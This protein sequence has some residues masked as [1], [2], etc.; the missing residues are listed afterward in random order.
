MRVFLYQFDTTN[1]TNCMVL[2]FID[3]SSQSLKRRSKTLASK[4]EDNMMLCTNVHNELSSS[5]NVPGNGLVPIRLI[6]TKSNQNSYSSSIRKWQYYH[7]TYFKPWT[8]REKTTK[9][10]TLARQIINFK[11]HLL[12]FIAFH[13]WI[14]G[15]ANCSHKYSFTLSSAPRLLHFPWN[16]P[17]R[18]P[19]R[20]SNSSATGLPT[21][22]TT[23]GGPA[24]VAS[25]QPLHE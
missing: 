18:P 14:D 12:P 13:I 9:R 11:M 25:R 22:L 1:R 10:C 7:G 16:L 23:S 3:A 20:P 2:T 19:P 5:S 8:Y 17:L 15:I 24:H 21:L 4:L 6:S